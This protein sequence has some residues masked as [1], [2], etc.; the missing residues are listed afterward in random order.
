[1][2]SRRAKYALHSLLAL[3]AEPERSWRTAELQ[4]L[5]GGSRAYLEAVLSALAREG[6]V[7]SFRG[8]SGGFRLGRPAEA[9]AFADVIRLFDGPLALAP[10]ASLTRYGRCDDCPNE[11]GCGV[12][13][14]LV[15]ARNA[16][17][18]VLE[19]TTLASALADGYR[20]AETS[21]SPSG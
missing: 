14:A 9:I 3:A 5:C 4:A 17:A 7:L 13:P 10:C 15:A 18:H 16:A 2:L 6:L 1:L 20:V 19:R 8:R 21:A 11:E 12:R